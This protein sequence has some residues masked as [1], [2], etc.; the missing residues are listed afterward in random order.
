MRHFLSCTA[1][2]LA[3]ATAPLVADDFAARL[4]IAQE[5][6]DHVPEM[7]YLKVFAES[8]FAE[9][10]DEVLE[11]LEADITAEELV[12]I[13][14]HFVAIHSELFPIDRV[15]P[16]VAAAYAQTYTL[17]ELAILKGVYDSPAGQL[18]SAKFPSLAA[19][20][21]Q[22]VD[23]ADQSDAEQVSLFID[24]LAKRVNMD[25]RINRFIDF[26]AVLSVDEDGM[27]QIKLS[28][29]STYSTSL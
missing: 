2:L 24:T 29:Y 11:S 14:E 23:G 18:I 28:E 10:C 25:E 12:V 16:V 19:N 7:A 9:T 20:M 8:D 26:H 1:L 13:S 17:E 15:K 21:L 3:T 22:V 27:L 6:V 4:A 5:I